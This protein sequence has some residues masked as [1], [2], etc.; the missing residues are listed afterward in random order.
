LEL[1]DLD[2]P[3]GKP[4]L[5]I[6]A[7]GVDIVGK[8][9]AELKKSTSSPAVIRSSTGGV[10]R[11]VAE[12]LARLGESVILLSAVG[13]DA[14][15]ERILQQ[16][17]HTG[18]DISAVIRQADLPTGSYLAIV[19]TRGELLY[20]LDDM[21]IISAV[22]REYLEE[23]AALFEQAAMVFLDANVSKDALRTAF[24]LAK[25]AHVPIVVDPASVILAS[26]LQPYLSQIFLITASASE[27]GVLS[28]QEIDP[29][30][31]PQA[32][33]VAKSLVASGVKVA[34][35]NLAEGGVCYATSDSCGFVPAIRT[36]IVD[37]TGAGDAMSAALIFALLNEFSIDEAVRLGV[38]ASTLT[39][40]NLGSVVEDLSLEKLYDTLVL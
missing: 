1:F 34:L 30:D 20:A 40:R 3:E 36:E 16:A 37:P 12:N 6:G 29:T 17:I 39:L 32:T 38:S 23:C 7:S 25:K 5:V 27:A 4:V 15:G 31:L 13:S 19:N 11:N 28:G 35:V 10:A 21:R 9:K 14:N 18:I 33:E 26:R 24:R 8:V 2:P 22:T